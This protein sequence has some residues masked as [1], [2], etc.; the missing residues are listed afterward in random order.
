MLWYFVWYPWY[1]ARKTPDVQ[2]I[3]DELPPSKAL[4]IQL[5][6]IKSSG[7]V[8]NESMGIFMKGFSRIGGLAFV[9]TL[10]F[11]GLMAYFVFQAD[12]NIVLFTYDFP[13]VLE[14]TKKLLHIDAIHPVQ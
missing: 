10:I 14:G 4:G 2:D 5:N 6:E 7:Q 8:F 11:S 13:G 3:K 1:K 12:Q 9:L